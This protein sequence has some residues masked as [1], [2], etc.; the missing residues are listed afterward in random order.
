MKILTFND[1][2]GNA[3]ADSFIESA[4][5]FFKL[6]MQY[7]CAMLEIQTKF[8]VLNTEMSLDRDHNS[9]ESIT[10]R[11]KQPKSIIEKLKRKN[12]DI[13]LENIE[14]YLHDVA[15]IRVICSFPEDIY[16][17]ADKICSQDDI[18]LIEKKDYI[19][20]P[21]KNGYRSLHLILEIP[22]FFANETKKMKV[23]VQLRTIAMDFW[24]SIEHKVRYKKD[25]KMP[26][27]IVK[28][29]KNCADQIYEMDLH[30]QKISH[31]IEQFN[32]Q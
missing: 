22:V 1:L 19:L 21:K 4:Q 29:L 8:Q 31:L 24:A 13:N 32:Q 16:R 3:D 11:I 14:T 12:I 23:E 30:M 26:D 18:S 25:L 6:M 15:G 9:I 10:C 17:L 7:K 28:D 27:N 2:M 5:P 20:N